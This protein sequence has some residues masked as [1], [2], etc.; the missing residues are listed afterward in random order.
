MDPAATGMGMGGPGG[1]GGMFG[2]GKANITV[3][4]KNSPNR[5]TFKDV[6]GCDEAKE[7]IMEFVQFLQ[8][9]AAAFGVPCLACRRRRLCCARGGAAASVGRPPLYAWMLGPPAAAADVSPVPLLPPPADPSK[10]EQ[11]GAK[12]PRGALLAGPPGTGKTLLAKAVAGEANVPFLTISGSDFMEMFVGV[13]PARVRDLFA[14]AR[15]MAPSIIFIDEIDAIGGARGKV[16]RLRWREGA[17]RSAWPEW[18]DRLSLSSRF[19]RVGPSSSRTLRVRAGGGGGVPPRPLL[20]FVAQGGAMGGHNERESTLNALLVEMDGFNTGS[21]VVVLGG[22]NRADMLD[23]A[24]LRPGRFD[25]S[26][27]W[28]PRLVLRTDGALAAP[29]GAG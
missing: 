11:L 14:Q 20:L 4:D 22:T 7:E 29:T 2:M 17:S 3:V 23:K 13:G 26:I 28:V 5:V 1:R 18:V 12:I 10:Y 15:Q 6:A 27:T 24:L 25:R 19:G 21:G 16:R 9:E 8:G